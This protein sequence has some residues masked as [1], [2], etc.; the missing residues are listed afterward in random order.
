MKVGLVAI[1]YPHTAYR[2]QMVARVRQ[3]A[4]VMERV[5]GCLA[6][7]C[8]TGLSDGTV[9]TIGQWGSGAALA[10]AFEAVRAA[11]IDFGYDER[12]SRPR[13]VL[14]LASI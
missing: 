9:V 10:A 6:V 7:G 5:P 14:R 1:H 4:E 13:E 2:D 11:G 12:E 8:W 3:A